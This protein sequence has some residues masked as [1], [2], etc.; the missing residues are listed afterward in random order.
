MKKLMLL[1]FLLVFIAVLG[2]AQKTKNEAKVNL[3]GLA[4]GL[5]DISYERLLNEK[6]AVGLSTGMGFKNGKHYQN[7]YRYVLLPYYK[8]YFGNKYASGFFL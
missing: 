6:M 7:Q 2:N 4:I 5:P 3:L 1:S 8:Y